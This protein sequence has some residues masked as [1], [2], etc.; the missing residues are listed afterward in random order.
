MINLERTPA[1]HFSRRMVSIK[2]IQHIQD[3][4]K[5]TPSANRLA[6]KLD[7]LNNAYILHLVAFWQVFIEDLA[8]YGFE[9]LKKGAPSH[10]FADIAMNRLDQE[11]KKFNT[12]NKENIERLF[13]DTLG[14]NGIAQSWNTE[15]LSNGLGEDTLRRVLKARHQI[16]HTGSADAELA[17]DANYRDM[18][19]LVDL[20]KAT[21]KYLEAALS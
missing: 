13:R 3:D 11:L 5:K 17:Y 12:P 10:A 15:K 4:L 6:L 8:R 19:I 9:I 2:F 21:E 14:I 18:N 7:Y 16:A 1:Q 20:A